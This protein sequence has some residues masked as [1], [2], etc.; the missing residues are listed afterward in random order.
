MLHGSRTTCHRLVTGSLGSGVH[1]QPYTWAASSRIETGRHSECQKHVCCHGE[2]DG[3]RS[4]CKAANEQDSNLTA[5]CNILPCSS[6]RQPWRTSW[7]HITTA[8]SAANVQCKIRHVSINQTD[9]VTST[10]STESACSR[11]GFMNKLHSSRRPITGHAY[12]EEALEV[13]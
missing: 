13:P 6:S 2:L 5:I 7:Y 9:M 3:S 10:F 11:G 4:C 1:E 8:S 12:L